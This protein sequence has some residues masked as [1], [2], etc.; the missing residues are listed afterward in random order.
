MIKKKP[1]LLV[2]FVLPF[3]ARVLTHVWARTRPFAFSPRFLWR[4]VCFFF[5]CEKIRKRFRFVYFMYYGWV[6][7]KLLLE[8]F[9]RKPPLLWSFCQPDRPSRYRLSYRLHLYGSGRGKLGPM[10]NFQA[11]RPVSRVCV[12][13]CLGGRAYVPKPGRKLFRR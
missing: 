10:L 4:F 8:A 9:D 5:L 2:P 1:F 3:Y 12:C 7:D 6:N 11:P 13:V